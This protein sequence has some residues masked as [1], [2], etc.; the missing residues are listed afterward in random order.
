[1]D[2]QLESP[3]CPHFALLYIDDDGKL[4][5]EASSSIA[6]DCHTI[7]SPEVTHSFLRA[8]ALSGDGIK[9]ID[10]SESVEAQSKSPPSPDSTE[11]PCHSRRSSFSQHMD[12][13]MKRKRVSHEYV[14]PMSI[15]C[16]PKTILPISNQSLLRKYYAKAFD[17]LQQ[18]N[19]RILAK[20]YIKLVEPRKQ[21]NF[22]YNGRKH[23]SGT[24]Q[25]FDPETTKPAWWPTGVTH[26][27]PDHLRKPARIRLLVHILC[28]LRESH[29]ICVEKLKEADQSIRRQI[30]PERLQVLDEIYHVRGEEEN[31][32]N[33]KID[34]QAVVCVSRVHLPDSQT[35]LYSPSGSGHDIDALYR[36]EIRDLESHTSVFPSSNS[37][38]TSPTEVEET[39]PSPIPSGA[40][41]SWNACTSTLPASV[42]SANPTMKPLA[43]EPAATPYTLDFSAP[44]GTRTTLDMP[45]FAMGYYPNSQFH[46]SAGPSQDPSHPQNSIPLMRPPGTGLGGYPQPY[47]FNY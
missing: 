10:A 8:V 36:D 44:Y 11:T 25:Q 20:A 34:D 26:R 5:F 19:C 42:P 38:P 31:Y 23:I 35:S 3:E 45:P 46:Q 4:R 41:T 2:P 1:M 33:G 17:S 43:S 6:D 32:L 13:H 37:S 21:V 27:E 24:P 39:T 22:P 14:V 9:P 18:T 15:T 47:Y 16:Y 30:S 40:P 28:E 29:A 12:N 7:L